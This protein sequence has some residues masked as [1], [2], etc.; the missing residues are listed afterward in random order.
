M[1]AEQ[2]GDHHRQHRV[3][4][5]RGGHG[6]GRGGVGGGQ[7]QLHAEREV[8]GADEAALLALLAQ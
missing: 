8:P 5:L 6:R 1:S 4:E 2:G 3:D 7:P